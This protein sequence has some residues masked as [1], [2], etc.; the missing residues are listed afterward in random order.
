MIRALALLLMAPAQAGAFELAFPADCRLGDTCFIQQFF[1]HDAGEGAA[2]FTCGPLVYDG[3]DG[4]DIALPSLA[5]MAAGTAVLAAAPGTVTGIRD[6]MADI[7]A[8]DPAAPSVENREC[9]NGVVID[10]GDGWE[11]QYCH[12]RQGSVSVAGGQKV[13]TGTPLGLIGMSGQAEFPHV[14]LSVR[15]N[16]TEIDPFAPNLQ[17]CGEAPTDTLW[18]TPPP[19]TPGGIIAAGF[20]A[21]VPEF[22]AIKSG[23]PTPDLTSQ[24]RALVL[25]AHVYGARAGDTLLIRITGPEGRLLAE[26]LPLEK[27]QARLFRAAGKRLKTAGWPLGPYQGTARLIRN[28]TEVDQFTLTTTL[29]N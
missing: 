2:D 29:V 17:T 19:Y 7:A 15:H 14:H 3:H 26:S 20:S 27:T 6:G 9:G 1:D 28:G 22:A 21:E 18:Q 24:S 16:G 4:T 13:E 5:A 12:M 23:L 25:W 11:T 10:H 8:N